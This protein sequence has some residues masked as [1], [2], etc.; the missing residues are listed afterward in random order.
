MNLLSREREAK[1]ELLASLARS[2][3]ALAR[4]L[5]SVADVAACSP[6]SARALQRE[7][8][9]MTRLQQSVAASIAPLR[10]AR[11]RSGKPGRVWLSGTHVALSKGSYAS[12][13]ASARQGP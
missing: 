9:A 2:Q 5:E 10:I 6:D 13:P 11:V 7:L 1:L 12:L 8:R 4:I 3:L